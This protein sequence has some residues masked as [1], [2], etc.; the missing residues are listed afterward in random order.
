MVRPGTIG[1]MNAFQEHASSSAKTAINCYF[2]SMQ[3]NLHTNQVFELFY[4][5]YFRLLTRPDDILV[6]Y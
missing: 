6:Y 4:N 5:R 1:E 3:I 2:P